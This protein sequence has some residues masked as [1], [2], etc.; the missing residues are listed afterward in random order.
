MKIV[1]T[2]THTHVQIFH[3]TYGILKSSSC[4]F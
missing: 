2:H 4:N 3:N 1:H